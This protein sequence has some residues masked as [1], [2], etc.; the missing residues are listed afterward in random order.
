MGTRRNP[1]A[2]ADQAAGEGPE[3]SRL[4]LERR[5]AGRGHRTQLQRVEKGGARGAAMTRLRGATT[6]Q[7]CSKY[8]YIKL[9]V[10][11]TLYTL[12]ELFSD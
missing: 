12:V 1:P 9:Q 11:Y 6:Q 3:G 8:S 7:E 10:I 5:G 4:A 2:E